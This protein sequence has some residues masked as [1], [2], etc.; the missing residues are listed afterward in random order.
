MKKFFCAAMAAL[1]AALTLAAVPAGATS[2]TNDAILKYTPVIDGKIDAAYLESYY[3]THNF[4]GERDS[5]NFW[6]N[7]KF[8]FTDETMSVT[9]YGFDCK[10]TM[11][12]LW[13]DNNIY[14]AVR[15]VDDDYGVIDDAHYADC[16]EDTTSLGP[17]LQDGCLV[18]LSYKG[19]TFHILADRAGRFISVFREANYNEAVWCDLYSWFEH[20]KN[21]DDGYFC[22]S[23]TS[24][25][26]IIEM[27]I[28]VS[29]DY[30]DKILKD[31]GSFKYSITCVDS[32]AD[33]KYGLHQG[34]LQEGIEQ[35][36]SNFEDFMVMCEGRNNVDGSPNLRVKLSS[37]EPT[38]KS[39]TVVDDS[40]NVVKN[41]GTKGT[42]GS[43]VNGG[44]SGNGS[45]QTGDAGIAIAAAALLSTAC[46]IAIKKHR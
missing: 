34:L 9:E 12:F 33:A 29:A 20:Q 19:M 1:I 46:F 43:T 28:P 35:E 15:V 45:A 30:R 6:G 23:Q 44:G 2:T 39:D 10:A 27:Q 37:A 4:D 5:N 38:A 42:T 40:G 24:D 18:Y 25:G 22:T 11:Y 16:L 31:G 32:P 17:W 21:A 36:A 41:D 14:I 13:D 7:G 3:S 26:Y 8:A